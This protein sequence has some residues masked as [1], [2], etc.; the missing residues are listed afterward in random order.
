MHRQEKLLSFRRLS[1]TNSRRKV[2]TL[3]V[4]IVLLALF[5]AGTFYK[6]EGSSVTGNQA[7][8]HSMYIPYYSIKGNWQ[9]ELTLNNA[10]I[11]PLTVS[12][13]LYSLNG[14]A[15]PLPDISIP[16]NDSAIV[17]ID[18]ALAGLQE[19]I[20]RFS[21]GSLE[22]RFASTDPMALGPQLTIMNPQRRVSFD[23]EPPMGLLT[24][25]LDGLWWLLNDKTDGKVMLC[26]T[27]SHPIE[28]TLE[29]EWKKSVLPGPSIKLSAHQT[30]I[31]DVRQLLKNNG[32]ATKGIEQGGLSIS[33]SGE[34][35]A[36]VAFGVIE[37]N[38]SRFASSL[39]FVDTKGQPTATLDGTGLLIGRVASLGD[40][41]D[42]ASFIPTL[43][44]K[45]SASVGQVA[46]VNLTYEKDGRQEVLPLP[47]MVLDAREVR[48]ANLNRITNLLG[49]AKINNASLKVEYDG[50]AGSIIGALTSVD[51]NG[52]GAV[53]VPLVS[54]KPKS[55]K[56]GNHPFRIDNGF[57]SVA[58]LTNITQTPTK[59]IVGIFHQNGMYT[60]EIIDI[61]A[62]GTVAIDFLELRG[63]QAKDIQGRVLPQNLTKG[64]FFWTPRGA[65]A[66]IGRVL[67][68]D[69][70]TGAVS[71]FSCPNCCQLEPSGL[72]AT[73]DPVVGLPGGFQQ[74]TVSSYES[75]CGQFTLGP[76]NVTNSVVYSSTN[77]SVMTVNSTG[78]VSF[79]S[80]G[81]S[82]INM[83][84]FFQHSDYISSEDCGLF[85][86]FVDA[87]C[88]GMV[89]PRVT[90]IDITKG[91]PGG[92]YNITITGS[93]FAAGATVS[94]DPTS[95]VTA[96]G[97]QVV[98]STQ[99]F[100]EFTVA[101]NASGGDRRVIVTVAGQASTDQVKFFVQIPT[102]VTRDSQ[103]SIT[104]CDPSL[105]TINGQPN[106]CGAFRT[107][108]YQIWD[109]RNP[110]QT[111]EEPGTVTEFISQWSDASET[112]IETQSDDVNANGIFA[113]LVGV[114]G[115][116]SACP[117]NGNLADLRQ[118]FSV[119]IN[120]VS[121]NLTTRRR[122][123]MSK[124]SGAYSINISTT[125]P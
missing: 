101:N 70:N 74:M 60:P 56:G 6:H 118:K 79:V 77:T 36:L 123:Q 66:L 119:S 35:G 114:T 88:P 111:V 69:E 8:T 75:Y 113:D 82:S 55:G 78:N 71:N 11:L 85:D 102:K 53:D 72:V 63:N 25:K 10:A 121:H 2:M 18:E 51:R 32:I 12:V 98:S 15:L 64:Q 96:G 28:S 20:G 14:E 16:S 49:K 61:D 86:D 40:S 89:A 4:S 52:A 13:T 104:T 80:W 39:N 5:L 41:S 81:S 9:S 122:I 58:Y 59:A 91:V 33:H 1:L 92:G 76:Y 43:T 95:G 116:G 7:P 30:M 87:S 46:K 37:D 90:S 24:S 50:E 100:T 29:I 45:N 44:L 67:M 84:L 34:P 103:S 106:K 68:I 73:P 19:A 62:G 110:A 105:C 3:Y 115:I 21:E 99:I 112:T 27:T 83:V 48:M 38:D 17:R 65:G 26:N 57:R 31:I 107:L 22:V 54:R 47:D 93:G 120:S 117:S 124:S 97:T 94:L 23:L 125:T 109:Q 108:T 42:K